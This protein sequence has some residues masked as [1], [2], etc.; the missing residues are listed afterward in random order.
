[1][2]RKK[3][4]A[5]SVVFSFLSGIGIGHLISI[6]VSAIITKGTDYS[7]VVPAFETMMGGNMFVA[8]LVAALVYGVI[9]TIFAV[10]NEVWR[11]EQW[12]LLTRTAV[13]YSATFIPMFLAAMLLRWFEFNVLNVL[14]FIGQFTVIFMIIWVINYFVIRRQIKV[15]NAKIKEKNN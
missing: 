4:L 9:G 5:L 1:M 3:V 15:I 10:A 13:Y 11:K 12:S 8:A 6:I 7:V 2:S 14:I